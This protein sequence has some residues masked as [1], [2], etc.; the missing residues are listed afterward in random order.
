[1]PPM[2]RSDTVPTTIPQLLRSAAVQHSENIA[3][4]VAGDRRIT[5]AR[6]AAAA[7][8]VAA[9][10]STA[11]G[12]GDHVAVLM[13]NS[14]AWAEAM[15]GTALAGRIGVL[16]NPRLTAAE[17]TY[18]V[19][20]SDSRVVFV[21]GL[22]P[23]LLNDLQDR[24]PDVTFTTTAEVATGNEAVAES[25]APAG[26]SDS[27]ADAFDPQATAV[28]IY[29][30]GTTSA[31]K[32]VELSHAALLQNAAKV[33]DRFALAGD[34]SVF[35]A[36]PFFHSGGLTMHILM[37]ALR[38][39]TAHSIVR[40][41]PDEVL[42][43]IEEHGITV[44]SGIETLFLRLLQAESF[45][46]SRMRS[47]RTGWTTGTPA[48]ADIIAQ[49]VG[50]PGVITVYGISEAGPNVFMS[51]VDDSTEHRLRTVG[52][53]LDG[54]EVRIIDPLTGSDMPDGV[55]GE[56]I[57]RSPSLMRSYYAKPEET[58]DAL[59]DGWLHTGDI[60]IR[61]PDG[62]F[63]FGGRSKD[64][65]RTFGE[66]VSCAEVEDAIYEHTDVSLTAVV[67]LPDPERGEIVAAAIV[68]GSGRTV[69]TQ[70]ALTEAL[71]LHL[72]AYKLPRRVAVLE[73]LPMTASGK[74]R[75]AGLQDILLQEGASL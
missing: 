63:E 13:P 58:A 2:S 40:F 22:N 25:G 44:Y 42:A 35:G 51:S 67:A 46:P 62:F 56:L 4:D 27:S 20:Q 71:A 21:D 24:L 33:A 57:V 69:T 53:P 15:Y 17:V 55:R 70:K 48:V 66:N 65:V 6:L 36:G 18:Q 19:T 3:V 23:E 68:P 11:T 26:D 60:L 12:E 47:V 74:V 52:R 38:G 61:R 34:D 41:G 31:P 75:K 16:L 5:Y 7:S 73:E 32:G 64:T 28:I 14:V 59:R 9:W 49:K 39:I 29:T 45:D 72:S 30:S 1:M 50:I 54:V 10:I 37:C 43:L 8:R